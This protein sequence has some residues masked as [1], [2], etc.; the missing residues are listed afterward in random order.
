MHDFTFHTFRLLLTALKEQQYTFQTF[1]GYLKDPAPHAI[2]LRHDVD[3]RKLN[4]LY[5][6]KLEVELGITGTYNF[7]MVPQSFDAEVIKQITAMGHEIG[8]H[9]EDLAT[10][11]GNYDQAIRLFKQNL[12]KLRQISPV[13]TICM[14]GSPLSKYDN[15]KIWDKYD[16]RNYGII[17]EPYFDLDFSTMLYLTDTGRRWDGE[18]VSVRDGVSEPRAK[19]QE[20]RFKKSG[21]LEKWKSGIAEKKK[22]VVNRVISE[23]D[24]VP[25]WRG[26]GEDYRT[27]NKL[28]FHS[29]YDIIKAATGGKLPDKIMINVH[30]QRCDDRVWPWIRE[31]LMQNLKNSVKRWIVKVE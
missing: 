22:S 1:A 13:E 3:G 24:D 19:S 21:K 8:Y 20:P 2:I 29:T 28:R 15:R 27:L 5:A 7:R 25:L 26:Q 17:G 10:A 14:H 11:K 12:A 4:S 6:A 30:P 9:Y 23:S 31:F 16:Y 18:A